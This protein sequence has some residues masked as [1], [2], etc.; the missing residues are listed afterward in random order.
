LNG[1]CRGFRWHCG[2]RGS[3]V[4]PAAGNRTNLAAATAAGAGYAPV[5]CSV[6]GPGDGGRELL[7]C[8]K[9]HGLAGR[10]NGNAHS[11]TGRGRR[12]AAT[13]AASASCGSKR[14]Q[15]CYSKLQPAGVSHRS[16]LVWI[17]GSKLSISMLH[18]ACKVISPR[19]PRAASRSIISDLPSNRVINLTIGRLVWR[20]RPG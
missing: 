19:A 16:S 11:R 12:T 6:S 8:A 20:R 15:N 9:A 1:L 14:Q 10:R 7:C 4:E 17:H 5:D 3:A 18:Y 2:G 13:A